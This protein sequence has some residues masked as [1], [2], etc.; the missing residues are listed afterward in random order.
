MKQLTSLAIWL[1]LAGVF[2]SCFVF[3]M[4][5]SSHQEGKRLRRHGEYCQVEV[6]RKERSSE[7]DGGSIS[8]FVHA[9]PVNRAGTAEPIQCDVQYSDY[10]ELYVGQKLKAWVLGDKASLEFGTKNAAS[11]ARTMLLTCTGSAAMLITGLTLKVVYRT[12]GFSQ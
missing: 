1:G 6:V 2:S 5:N 12:K 9:K 4:A 10:N 11:V 7:A 3:W 8:Y